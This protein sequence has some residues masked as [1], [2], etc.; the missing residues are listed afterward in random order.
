MLLEIC[1]RFAIE[2]YI[3]PEDLGLNNQVTEISYLGAARRYLSAN[4]ASGVCSFAF[5]RA[6]T[7][8]LKC[9]MD[10]AA[11]L[12]DPVFSKTIEDEV[13]IPLEEEKNM[14]LFGF[15]R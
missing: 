8:C 15:P 2:D 11:S 6:V 10:P 5:N 14:L 9:F 4:K 3:K 7:Y 12:V 1:Y 13:L